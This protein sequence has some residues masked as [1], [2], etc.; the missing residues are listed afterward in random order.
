MQTRCPDD[1]DK[2][3]PEV[4]TED[5]VFLRRSVPELAQELKWVKKKVILDDVGRR[6]LTRQRIFRL[7]IVSEPSLMNLMSK[8]SQTAFESSVRDIEKELSYHKDC[9]T[10]ARF[11]QSQETCS[12]G[13]HPSWPENRNSAPIK[14]M[15]VDVSTLTSPL[16]HKPPG[17]ARVFVSGD[18]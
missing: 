8:H 10:S 18:F 1:F 5:I 15:K 7:E 6:R 3:L 17:V 9:F 16:T 12:D 4:T 14:I 13:N 2:H 11:S